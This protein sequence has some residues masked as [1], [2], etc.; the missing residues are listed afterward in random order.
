MV[1]SYTRAM[2]PEEVVGRQV[3]AYNAHDL[4]TFV[5][6]YAVDVVVMS[7]TG[8]VMMEGS[9]ALRDQYGQWFRD[10]PDLHAEVL[11]RVAHESWVVDHERAASPSLG[12]EMEGLIAYRIQGEVID[13]VVMMATDAASGA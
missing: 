12:L 3:D 11:G 13:R 6:C 2:S 5:A 7:G 4:E 10:M 8:E 1:V 9:D